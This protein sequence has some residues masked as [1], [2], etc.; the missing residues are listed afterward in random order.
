MILSVPITVVLMI[1]CAQFRSTRGLAIMLSA[2][3]KV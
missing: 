3:G 2:E 1:V